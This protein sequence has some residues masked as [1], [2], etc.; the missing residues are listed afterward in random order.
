MEFKG[1]KELHQTLLWL[2]TN[3]RMD[4]PTSDRQVADA[5]RSLSMSGSAGPQ[6][7]RQADASCRLTQDKWERGL[8]EYGWSLT[9]DSS[10]YD[11]LTL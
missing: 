10:T 5:C 8:K 2:S 3:V 9:Y 6:L 11:F 7:P 4:S 1:G